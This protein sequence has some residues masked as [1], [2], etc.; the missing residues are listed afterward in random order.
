MDSLFCDGIGLY[1]TVGDDTWFFLLDQVT[2]VTHCKGQIVIKTD[3]ERLVFKGTKE[4]YDSI[5]KYLAE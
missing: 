5:M 1:V 3:I 2:S 4:T